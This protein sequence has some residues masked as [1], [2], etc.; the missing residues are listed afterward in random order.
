MRQTEPPAMAGGFV[1]DESANHGWVIR[2][3]EISGK[4]ATRPS[5]NCIAA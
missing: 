5:G 2:R 4:M 1:I 3:L